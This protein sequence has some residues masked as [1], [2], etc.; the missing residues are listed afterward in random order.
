MKKFLVSIV[1]CINLGITD[2]YARSTVQCLIS[3]TLEDGTVVC[4]CYEDI[5]GNPVCEANFEELDE[6]K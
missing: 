5:D 1:L 2:L 6:K 4:Y 3:E